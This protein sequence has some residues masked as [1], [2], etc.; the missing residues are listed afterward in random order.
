MSE[1]TKERQ[2]GKAEVQP[3]RVNIN[4]PLIRQA[5]SKILAS[6][7]LEAYET[8]KIMG[9]EHKH[10]TVKT[11]SIPNAGLGVFASEDIAI[12][13]A[14]EFCHSIVL[15]WRKKYIYDRKLIQYAYS[16][17]DGS[18][19]SKIHGN[20]M[21]L[22]LGYG[23][24]YNSAPSKK[25]SN[26][27]FHVLPEHNLTVFLAIKPIKAGEEILTW[28]GEGYYNAWCRPKETKTEEHN[29]TKETK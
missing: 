1:E 12:N 20:L 25:E 18:Q 11:S 4:H 10:L 5:E 29:E 7:F 27:E 23:M 17:S 16:G 26:C 2:P 24:I 6:H 15:D 8:F 3:L 9:L 14:I 21:V 13:D 22:P 19:E 28:W